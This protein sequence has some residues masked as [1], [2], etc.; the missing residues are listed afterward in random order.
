MEGGNAVAR[1]KV[2]D[3]VTVSGI[4]YMSAE[5]LHHS[6]RNSQVLL[7]DTTFSTNRFNWPLCLICA[8]D[9]HYHTVLLG[10]A[11]LQ[12]QTVDSFEW[13]RTCFRVDTCSSPTSS[14]TGCAF[15]CSKSDSA[16]C[17]RSCQRCGTHRLLAW[18]QTSLW[19][20]LCRPSHQRLQHRHPAC[21]TVNDS[22]R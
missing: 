4:Y 22:V 8:V 10:F 3:G 1:I 9:E 17:V 19:T 2:D 11:V 12:Y 20:S 7:M 16:G 6:R 14:C 13:V 21:R 18:R 15:E 5:M